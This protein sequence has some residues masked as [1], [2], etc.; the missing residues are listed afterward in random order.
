MARARW[1]HL[2]PGSYRAERRQLIDM[3]TIS[4]SSSSP[5]PALS[6]TLSH[7]F[8]WWR[9]EL[10]ALVPAKL[11][12]WWR[13][14]DRIVLLSF[15]GTRAVF[16]RPT[17]AA[18]DGTHAVELGAGDPSLHRAEIGRRLLH[19]AGTSFRLLLCLPPEQVLRR[20]LALPLAV[21]EN[22]RQALAFELD[23][24]TPF[25]AEQVY[26]DFRVLGRDAD[27]KSLSVELAAVP[28]STV[29]QGVA[30]A[31]TLGLTVDG[32]V[33]TDDVVQHGG[34]CRNFLP[35]LVQG[36]QPSVRLRWRAGMAALAMLLLVALLAIPVWQKYA[37]ATALLE[38]LAQAKAA[39]QKSDALRDRLS[40]LVEEHNF[41]HD[42]KWDTPS[43]L[44]VLEELSKL[45]PDDTFVVQLIFDGKTVEIQGD[46]A[47]STSL[48][49][50]LEASP[51][52]KDVSF[53]S[54][55]TKMPGTRNDRFHLSATLKAAAK[56][57]PPAV[58]PDA[59]GA[60]AVPDSPPRQSIGPAAPDVSPHQPAAPVSP[61]GKP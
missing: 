47:S 4:K 19:A 25:R 37:A 14:S 6:R 56:P 35:A 42:K 55:L 46:T 36:H 20:T 11:R 30:R 23:R 52:F 26:F 50:M 9:G 45:L 24:Y 38:P 40:K 17:G 61:A 22:L 57:K 41:L 8:A 59:A 33:L 10:T 34:D 13:E 44:L 1:I 16:E 15:D 28:R 3:V 18:R 21:E 60:T 29:D 32:A 48:V 58:A 53:K 2:S 39:A 43:A 51:L 5:M 31:A 54:Q 12:L 27:R 49:E 7:F